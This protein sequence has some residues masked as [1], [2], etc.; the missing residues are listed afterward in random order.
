M[1]FSLISILTCSS[2]GQDTK[3]VNKLISKYKDYITFAAGNH[4]GVINPGRT[5]EATAKLITPLIFETLVSINEREQLQPVLASSWKVN[6]LNKTI[7]FSLKHNHYFSNGNLITAK[8]V[9]NSILKRCENNNKFTVSLYGLVGCQYNS[10][11]NTPAVQAL[12]KYHV[13]FKTFVNPTIFLYQL[14]TAESVI[15]KKINNRLIGSGP[16]SIVKNTN[17]VLI[18]KKNK[19]FINSK[20]IK[21]KGFIIIHI[22]QDKLKYYITHAIFDGFIWYTNNSMINLKNKYYIA[23]K[24]KPY[25][26]QTLFI[27]N[28]RFPFNHTIL[29]KALLATIYNQNLISK[30]VPETT[31]SFGVIPYGLGGSTDNLAPNA[32]KTISPKQVFEQIP[33]L[34]K[35]YVN[36]IIHQHIGRKNSCL[37]HNIEKAASIYHIRIKFKYHNSYSSLWPLYLNHN[38]DGFVEFMLFRNREAFWVLQALSGSGIENFPNT[39]NKYLKLLLL[40]AIQAPTRHARFLLY[41]KL[42]LYLIKNAVII[43]LYYINSINLIKKC[44][45][46][47]KSGFYFNPYQY[48][49]KLYKTPACND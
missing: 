22:P 5:Q 28:Q 24:N 44:I 49:P 29:R 32:L 46:G 17:N 43:P 11:K 40:K 41:R 13:R 39:N 47:T 33:Q 4:I 19:L 48:F 2:L 45:T 35:K 27:N 31:R 37:A 10:E 6:L 9:V 18:I 1:I 21:N 26:T 20:K 15:Y 36:I 38:L 23:L 8:D 30:C 25:I 42:N 12:D 7:T 3:Q 34:K 14:S 16:Y